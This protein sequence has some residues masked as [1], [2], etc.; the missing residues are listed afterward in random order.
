MHLPVAYGALAP[1]EQFQIP[2]TAFY[3]GEMDLKHRLR[4]L[5]L[6]TQNALI[7]ALQNQ[8]A[9]PGATILCPASDAGMIR[10]ASECVRVLAVGSFLQFVDM[11]RN[12]LETPGVRGGVS[13]RIGWGDD[14]FRAGGLRRD[15]R[16]DPPQSSLRMRG[17]SAVIEP[18]RRHWFAMKRFEAK[19][20][21]GLTHLAQ[22]ASRSPPFS[23]SQS[24]SRKVEEKTRLTIP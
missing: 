3:V 16:F 5:S 21:V 15:V 19:D 2:P 24:P 7:D 8:E 6:R 18:L 1:S 9:R 22:D 23:F 17:F 13:P 11:A 12:V 4:D 20:D 10:K 14:S